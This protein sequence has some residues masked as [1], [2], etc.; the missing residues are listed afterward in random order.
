MVEC[1]HAFERKFSAF[2]YEMRGFGLESHKSISRRK[3]HKSAQHNLITNHEAHACPGYRG[4]RLIIHPHQRCGYSISPF[5]RIHHFYTAGSRNGSEGW[6]PG[7]QID[8]NRHNSTNT[9]PKS[10]F[11]TGNLISGRRKAFGTGPDPQN[12]PKTCKNQPNR[13]IW[14]QNPRIQ[15]LHFFDVGKNLRFPPEAACRSKVDHF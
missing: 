11:Y 13:S 5:A 6:T 9:L 12:G 8:E 7:G 1:T 2:R 14:I 10:A 3:L 4:Y 15:G